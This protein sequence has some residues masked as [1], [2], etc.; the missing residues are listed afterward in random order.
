[1]SITGVL[2]DAGYVPEKSTVG[3]KPILVGVYRCLFVDFKDE[4][5]GKYGPQFIAA[6]KVVETLAGKDSRSTFPE[7][8]GYFKTDAKGAMSK[9]DGIRKLF[10]GF[11]SV[12]INIDRSTDEVLF[13][14]LSAQKGV[15]ELY[16]L[17]KS[18]K[19]KKNIGTEEAPDWV[20]N[21]DA[22]DK[23]DFLFMTQKNAENEAKKMQKAAGHPLA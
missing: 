5:N 8:K 4:P 20:I 6:F 21:E 2:K 3:D 11:L 15:A 9:K 7:F 14:S 23:Q 1:M 12:G 13:E 10:D 18:K 19:P 16:I 17:G 22:E